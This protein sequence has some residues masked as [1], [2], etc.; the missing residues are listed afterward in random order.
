MRAPTDSVLL[1]IIIG[2][3]D[4]YKGR[5]LYTAILEKARERGLAGA[6]VFL[7]LEGF[8]RSRH[9]RA[10]IPVDADRRLPVLI[11]IIDSADQIDAFLPVLQEMVESG[12]VTLERLRAIRMSR[13]QDLHHGSAAA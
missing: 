3:D 12:L 13:Q 5:L 9:M 6:T 2:E 8:G 4:R 10:A 7:C 11:E 1:R